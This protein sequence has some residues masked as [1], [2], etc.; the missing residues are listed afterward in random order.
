[1]LN[2]QLNR[3]HFL[4]TL[5][6]LTVYGMLPLGFVSRAQDQTGGD[7]VLVVVH[8][9]GGCDGLNTVIP[10]ADPAYAT[11]RPSLAIPPA[12]VV[13]IDGVLGLHPA[14]T[15]LKTWYDQGLVAIVNGVGY[16]GFSQSHFSAEDIYW[17]A[18]PEDPHQATGWLG[19][20]LDSLSSATPLSGASLESRVPK[21]MAAVDCAV[22]AIPDAGR[23]LFKTPANAV[24]GAAQLTA[25][26]A[27]FSQ[28][29]TGESLFDGL[30]AADVA[31]M[32]SV[33]D[34]QAAVAAYE[35]PVAY[36]DD[37]F[38]QALKLAG[39]L[40]HADLGVRVLTV[41]Q[42]SYDTHANQSETLESLLAEFSSGIDAFIQ[43]AIQGGFAERV[44]VLVWTEF[45]RRVA[46]NASGGTDH[47]SAAPMFLIGQ[48]VRGGLYGVYPSLTDL[49]NGNLKM[50]TDFRGI[51][52]S[53]LDEWLGFDADTILGAT[54]SRLP[55]FS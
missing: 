30:L 7:R 36:G 21:S 37:T 45:G 40:I 55:L 34:V 16:P 22:P 9:D 18:S 1:M 19:R 38:G 50:T 11:A 25:A 2:M 41:S 32:D 14:L 31:A 24:E 28:A 6:A 47:G 5:G 51:Y 17:T 10:H 23:Y 13:D 26:Q 48:Q 39:Q 49:D 43:D 46:E 52:A 35:S 27:I 15:T 3:R 33:E 53:V 4:Q 20:G 42:G 29:P 8:L 54:W 12:E 44:L